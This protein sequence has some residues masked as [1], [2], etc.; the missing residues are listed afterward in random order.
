MSTKPKILVV[1]SANMDMVIQS[2]HFPAPGETIIGGDFLLIPGGKGANQAV[3]ASRLGGDVS[4]ISKLGQDLFGTQNLLNYQ[5]AGIDTSYIRQIP[6]VPSGVALITVDKNGENT[7]IVAPGAN[8]HL[9]EADIQ[10]NI[11]AFVW[12]DIVLLQLEIP[13]ATVNEVVKICQ[14]LQKRLILNPAPAAHLS[15]EILEGLF[16]I[17]PNE[18]EAEL[19]TG[20]KVIDEKSAQEAA[21]YFEL[22]GVQNVIITLGPAG[23]YVYT[24][25]YQGILPTAQVVAKDTTAAGDTFNGALAV[26]LAQ[27]KSMVEAVQYALKAATL[28][29]Q[30]M[31]AQ[32][33]IPFSHE[34]T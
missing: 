33:S 12:A 18:T 8:H 19:L 9:L 22:K 20:V 31:G 13:Y 11:S 15:D 26:A 17:S 32:S 5:Q 1:G 23:A 34:L 28:S 3:A 14:K 21:A 29:V 30:R 25:A 10:A 7:I 4:F 6:D 2:N 24:K 16:M 27:D